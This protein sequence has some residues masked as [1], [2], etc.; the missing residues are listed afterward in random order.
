MRKSMIEHLQCW[1][2]ATRWKVLDTK[3]QGLPQSRPRF[4]LV[5]IF[6]SAAGFHFPPCIEPAPLGSLLEGRGAAPAVGKPLRAAEMQRVQAARQKL[7]SKGHL[8]EACDGVVDV[9]SS[10][11]WSSV[12]RGCSPCLTASRAKTGG[13]Y[14]L[15]FQRRMTEKE[16][17]R[18]QGI[19][20]G[21]FDYLAAGVTQRQFLQAVGNAMTSAV[22]AR[23]FARA[24]PV[25]NL[26]QPDTVVLPGAADI[27]EFLKG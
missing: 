3:S 5:A 27:I 7:E 9:G 11:K 23:I 26:A 22:V 25:A 4:Y 8:P 2:Y 18:L 15:T 21:R 14:L 10:A 13:H 20:D 6:G 16:V 12:M 24:L 19:P 1:G 17:C